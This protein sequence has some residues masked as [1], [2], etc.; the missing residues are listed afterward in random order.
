MA[1]EFICDV[2][3]FEANKVS[4]SERGWSRAYYQAI[5]DA[6]EEATYLELLRQKIEACHLVMADG[7]VIEDPQQINSAL[8]DKAEAQL[9]G[10]LGGLATNSWVRLQSMGNAGV[11]HSSGISDSRKTMMTTPTKTTKK[12]TATEITIPTGTDVTTTT[13]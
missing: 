9:I 3:G 4:I 2:P 12:P 5:I 11:R 1:I 13:V 10:F 6:Q 7:S 8:L